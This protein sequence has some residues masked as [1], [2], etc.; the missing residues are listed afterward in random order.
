LERK[1]RVP[2]RYATE[3]TNT[4]SKNGAALLMEVTSHHFGQLR[5]DGFSF[6]VGLIGGKAP[7]NKN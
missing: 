6:E 2:K 4:S 7:S 3:L 5:E 1:H